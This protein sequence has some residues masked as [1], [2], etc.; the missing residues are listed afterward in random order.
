MPHHPP[1]N[2]LAKRSARVKRASRGPAVVH[3]RVPPVAKLEAAEDIKDLRNYKN[4]MASARQRF[5]VTVLGG[6]KPLT[7]IKVVLYVRNRRGTILKA[8]PR[9][10]RQGQVRQSIPKGYTV[11]FI[12]PVP[13]AG[14]WST[15]V[16]AP[17]SRNSMAIECPP[18]MPAGIDGG[19]WWHR[20]MGVD[21]RAAD[22]GKGIRVGIIDTGCG[23]HRNLKHVKLVGVFDGGQWDRRQ[24]ATD[25]DAEGHGTHTTGII[26]ARRTQAGDYWGMAPDCKLFHARGCEDKEEDLSP[27]NIAK[28]ISVLSRDY[29]CDLINMSLGGGRPSKL[30][31]AAIRS[32]L[33]RGTLCIC[34]AG[35]SDGLRQID[36]PA[37]FSDCVAVSAIGQTGRAPPGTWA[38]DQRPERKDRRGRRGLFLSATTKFGVR[39]ACAGP[40]V[41]I[42]STVCDR[43]ASRHRPS[44]KHLY[45]EM[46]GA[47]MASAAVCGALAVILSKSAKYKALPRDR[48]RAEAARRLL[49]K[50]CKSLYLKKQYQG[51]GLPHV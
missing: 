20:V 27:S 33:E 23:P 31:K 6:G 43:R 21:V 51:H 46:E 50:H 36:H 17:R 44:G 13:Y 7:D 16:A 37:A 41:G 40:G 42:V 35:N 4:L 11:A 47:S 1:R 39:L 19:G 22:R 34:S 9:T 8:R 10:N 28:A 3:H 2:R 48:S 26:G 45:M 32:A 49:I 30:E 24:K 14:F 29:G 25:V 15:L 12:R 5:V 38:G 18:L